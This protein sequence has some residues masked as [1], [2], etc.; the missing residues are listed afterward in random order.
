MERILEN[1]C[2]LVSN[3]VNKRKEGYWSPLGRLAEGDGGE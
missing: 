3:A 1:P 2:V